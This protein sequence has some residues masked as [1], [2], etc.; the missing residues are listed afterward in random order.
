MTRCNY[1]TNST[2]VTLKTLFH[3]KMSVP[4]LCLAFCV[5]VISRNFL[6]SRAFH[7]KRID[8]SPRSRLSLYFSNNL[9]PF[10]WWRHKRNKIVHIYLKF[11]HFPFFPVIWSKRLLYFIRNKSEGERG[12]K[13][14][15]KG[16][17]H[18]SVLEPETKTKTKT[19]MHV[20]GLKVDV[21]ERVLSSISPTCSKLIFSWI[22]H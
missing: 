1:T 8:R 12:G 20:L 13:F 2:L 14:L 17:R 6:S 10:D 16:F 7:A 18:F 5:P 3:F 11:D 9:S 19:K 22:S 4:L 21:F 15:E